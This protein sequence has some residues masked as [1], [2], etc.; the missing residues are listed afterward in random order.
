MIRNINEILYVNEF[1]VPVFLK[2]KPF[3]ENWI[4]LMKDGKVRKVPTNG[5]NALHGNYWDNEG[6]TFTEAL[7]TMPIHGGLSFLLSMHNNLACIDIDGCKADD[8]RLKKILTLSPDAWCEFS[9]S[10]NGV[11]VW[12]YLPYKSSYLLPGR[13]TIG[14]C[15]K[16]Y[17][18]YGSGRSITI[19]GHHICGNSFVDLTNAVKFCE[20]LRPKPIECVNHTVIPIS[21][22]VDTILKKAFEREPPLQRMYYLGHSWSDKSA[23]DFYFCQRMWFWLGGHG[24]G[25]IENVFRHS[26]LYRESKGRHYVALTIHNASKRW[27]GKYYGFSR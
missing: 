26:A 13:T 24:V 12:G 17:E 19:T 22:D 2:E 14:Y 7:S 4:P 3:W 10:G 21:I 16:E 11:H 5:I 23:E 20:S 18:W 6:R 25:A 8:D 9:P 15:G 27:N 1:G